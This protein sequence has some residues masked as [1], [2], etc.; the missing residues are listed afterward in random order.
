MNNVYSLLDYKYRVYR[1]SILRAGDKEH[2]I[3]CIRWRMVGHVAK[4]RVAEMIN[5]RVS[6]GPGKRLAIQS[7]ARK[8]VATE[9]ILESAV[10]STL[11]ERIPLA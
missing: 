4:T 11:E 8:P 2:E 7:E 10:P 1:I 6:L 3:T 9:T 5:R